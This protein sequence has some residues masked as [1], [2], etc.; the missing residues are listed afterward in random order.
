MHHLD[1]IFKTYDVL[2]NNSLGLTDWVMTK[3]L[4]VRVNELKVMI[5][6]MIHHLCRTAIRERPLCIGEFFSP[7]ADGALGLLTEKW[8]WVGV[9]RLLFLLSLHLK[10]IPGTINSSLM[11]LHFLPATKSD[12][13]VCGL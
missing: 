10:S 5:V 13:E 9:N 8:E 6:D 2:Q 1:M 7:N 4:F 11:T 3:E 12:Q